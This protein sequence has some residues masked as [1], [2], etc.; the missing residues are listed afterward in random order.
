MVT[1]ILRLPAIQLE[2]GYSRS[3][4]YLRISQ[5]LWPRPVHLGARAVGWP[6]S[7]IE[8]LNTARIAGR[9]DEEIRALV[10]RLVAARKGAA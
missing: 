9:S 6:A 2:S 8:A 3:T 7:E 1:A 4:I 10:A 5:G